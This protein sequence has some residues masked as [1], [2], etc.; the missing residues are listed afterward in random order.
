[1]H[2]NKSDISIIAFVRALLTMNST[3]TYRDGKV[4]HSK[5]TLEG[6]G[7]ICQ[8]LIPA[9]VEGRTPS[10]EAPGTFV[11]I[12]RCSGSSCQDQKV[13]RQWACLGNLAVETQATWAWI[14]HTWSGRESDASSTHKK[15]FG[16]ENDAGQAEEP[17]VV[18]NERGKGRPCPLP[19]ARCGEKPGGAK[20]S[21]GRHAKRF[22]FRMV[23]GF[24]CA[25]RSFSM[26]TAFGA[27]GAWLQCG[28]RGEGESRRRWWDC[29]AGRA[30]FSTGPS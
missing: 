7:P 22:F 6:G 3:E 5:S 11:G 20:T 2:R 23:I 13:T 12:L 26:V 9:N 16:P 14:P 29:T 28:G 18:G 4:Y 27:D 15:C 21:K 1:M 24:S 30:W 8:A 25:T 19:R 10:E 17:T